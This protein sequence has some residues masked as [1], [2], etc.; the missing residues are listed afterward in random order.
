MVDGFIFHNRPRYSHCYCR[1]CCFYSGDGGGNGGGGSIHMVDCCCLSFSL[2]VQFVVIVIVCVS[3]VV[4]LCVFC[5]AIVPGTSTRSST[6]T[7]HFTWQLGILL[8]IFFYLAFFFTRHL[9]SQEKFK[10][11][12]FYQ[13]HTTEPRLNQKIKRKT[14]AKK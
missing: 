11:L 3:F 13:E 9:F 1:C 5:F 2:L 14:V 8:G 6:F 10:I 12:R 7:R 4:C